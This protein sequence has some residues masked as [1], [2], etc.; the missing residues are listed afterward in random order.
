MH[1]N[2]LSSRHIHTSGFSTLEV[3]I[4]MGILILCISAVILVSFGNQSILT[5][6]EI[7]S[8]ALH[9]A[10][11]YLQEAQALARQDFKLV[12]PRENSEITGPITFTKTLSVETLPDLLTKEIQSTVTWTGEHGR[13]QKVELTALVTNFENAIG[14]DTCDSVLPAGWTAP[15]IKNAVTDFA[16]LVGDP[17]GIYPVTGIDAS[18]G[19]LYVTVN[20][21]AANTKETFFIFSIADPANPTLVNKI[22][23]ASAI[24]AGLN[25]A[26]VAGKYAYVANG[27]GAPFTTCTE[28]SNCAQLQVID[29]SV[30]PPQV[31]KNYKVPGVTGTANQA[32]GKSIFYKDG[33]VYLG[34]AKTA[35][36]PEFHILDVHDPANPSWVGA[37]SVG[38]DVN[39]IQVKGKYAYL[40]TP[41]TEELT[42]LDVGDPAHPVHAGGFDGPG[43]SNGKSL[44]LVGD[45]LYVGR[46]FGG[47]EFYVLDNKNPASTLLALGSKDLG[48]TESAN[49]LLVR[50]FLA[51]LLTNTQ[52]Q[53]LNISNPAS[54]GSYAPPVSLP[55]GGAGTALACEGNYLF[56]E[57][58]SAGL[59]SLSVIAP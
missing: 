42:T 5:D 13:E 21:T 16:A 31:I 44:T 30:A 43:G 24:S 9:K 49:G 25:A 7:N 59:G 52:L 38:H 10:E 34:L 45:M 36:G 1:R 39:D 54:I 22:D 33:Y 17:A 6:A 40:A 11:E 12:L 18:H 58:V 29:I 2:F 47:D 23:N 53:I 26:H 8:E 4:A 15:L 55:N 37:Y 35:S 20:N 51:F 3:L 32:I 48:A 50:D 28:G 27:Y 41:D 19:K 57:A 46:T 14:G 56:A